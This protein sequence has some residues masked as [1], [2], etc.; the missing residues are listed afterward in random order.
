MERAEEGFPS[1]LCEMAEASKLQKKNA[2]SK[3]LSF[4][5][6]TRSSSTLKEER[7]KSV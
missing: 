7:Q 4:V 1:K 6:N 5:G 3:E 2:G